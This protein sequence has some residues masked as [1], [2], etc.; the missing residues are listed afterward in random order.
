MPRCAPI[1]TFAGTLFG[2][3]LHNAQAGE[4]FPYEVHTHKLDNGMQVVVV[5]MNAPGVVSYATWMAVGSRDEVDAGRTGFAHFFEHLMFLGTPS[6]DAA[7]REKAMLRM[8]ADDNAWTWF[9]ETV[10]HV[11]L[12]AEHLAPLLAIE[13]DR[14]M[15]L[16]LTPDDVRREAGAVYGEFR[17]GKV[18]PVGQAIEA[19]YATAFTTHTYGHDTIGFEADIA[20]MPTGHAYAA[21][22]FD[23]FYRPGHA[24]LLVVGDVRPEAV[25]D[26]V[27]QTFGSWAAGT[28]ARPALPA[29]PPQAGMR[30]RE[31]AWSTPTAPVLAMG[32]RAPAFDPG[33]LDVV[34][35]DLLGSILLSEIGPL[36]QRLVREEGLAFSVWG[37]LNDFVDPGLFQV[38]AV[39]R[40]DADLALAEAIVRE[41]IAKVV[42]GVD[43]ALLDRVRTQG[44]Y[45]L[46]S[47]LDTPDAVMETLGWMMRRTDG[48]PDAVDQLFATLERVTA[49]DVSRVARERLVDDALSVVTLAHD[50]EQEVVP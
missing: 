24:T 6:L 21:A 34:T 33:D 15:H 9:D 27:T 48:A 10:Y 29:E 23:R 43:P 17:K 7:G 18:S 11:T 26:Q 37:G 41:E 32:W 28:V 1:V 31:V 44:R 40:P 4:V 5:P 20:A 14:F 49:E 19:L 50:G 36:E 8:A 38:T 45:A 16:T 35:L 39:L 12:P 3:L 25:V 47:G 30:R 42:Q 13:A 2:L 46:L 22:F